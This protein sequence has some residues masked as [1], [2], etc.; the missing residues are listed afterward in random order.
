MCR[1]SALGRPMRRSLTDLLP[2]EVSSHEGS[3]CRIL[4]SV[5]AEASLA[6]GCSQSVAGWQGTHAGQILETTDS[7]DC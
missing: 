1:S 7:S 4:K 3:R 2:Q 5:T 6:R